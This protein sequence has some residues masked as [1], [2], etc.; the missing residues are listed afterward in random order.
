MAHYNLQIIENL[1]QYVFNHSHTLLLKKYYKTLNT[2][3]CKSDKTYS[4]FG[5]KEWIS[6][7]PTTLCILLECRSYKSKPF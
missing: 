1:K 2:L 6:K 3:F 4:F 7:R 5:S